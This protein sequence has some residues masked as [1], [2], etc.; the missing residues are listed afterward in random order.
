VPRLRSGLTVRVADVGL[1]EI[2]VGCC[3]LPSQKV[4]ITGMPGTAGAGFPF[5]NL[6]P[7][8]LVLK[9]GTQRP[10]QAGNFATL[11]TNQAGQLE[12]CINEDNLADN[13]GAWGIDVRIDE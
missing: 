12:L 1:S 13:S 8:A 5:A 3:H 4:G 9:F 7:Y 11:V 2:D 6:R 10:V